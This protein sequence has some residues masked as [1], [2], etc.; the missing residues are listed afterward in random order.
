I[1]LAGFA[2]LCVGL[3]AAERNWSAVYSALFH[4]ISAFCNAG[5]SLYSD[6]LCRFGGN[7]LVV[8]TVMVLIVLGG[9]GHVVLRELQLELRRMAL[10]QPPKYARRFSFH[11]RVVL[12][13]SGVLVLGGAAAL[14]VFGLGTEPGSGRF[15][16]ALFQSITARTAGFNTV[17]IGR[18]TMPSA[19]VVMLLMFIGGSPG[20]CAGGIKTTSFAIW[21]ARIRS[22]L[23]GH[24]EVSLL[25]RMVPP[26]LVL[27]AVAV[28]GLAFIWN[29]AGVLIL[30]E[31]LPAGTRLR[32]IVFE[33]MSAFGTVGLSTGL[34][35][36]L[37]AACRLWIIA[38]MFVGRL[39]PLTLVL[40]FLTTKR[41]QTRY[42]EGRVMIG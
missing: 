10:R 3:V 20:S 30:A 1:E 29:A 32:D 21:L 37:T 41:P 12:T 35:S 2:L 36:Q 4:T 13:V 23:H 39:G 19:M 27:R 34:T 33:Q 17:D 38:T 14:A 24:E 8:G 26:E 7:G 28:V 40:S 25:G 42:A 5:F 6:S 11:T 16:Q 9:L 31:F 15:G 18:L 22:A